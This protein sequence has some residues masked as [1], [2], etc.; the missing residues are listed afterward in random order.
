MGEPQSSLE[1]KR[2]IFDELYGSVG[3]TEVENELVDTPVFQ[4]LRRIQ[5]LG[6]VSLVY[7]GATHTRFSHSIGTVF[8]MDRLARSLKLST[9]SEILQLLRLVA[10]L[11]D[12]GHLP[13]SHMPDAFLK[14]EGHEA[15]GQRIIHE[16]PISDILTKHRVDPSEIVKVLNKS[17][18]ERYSILIDSDL[19]VDKMDYLMRDAHHTGVSY[20]IVDLD[21]LLR[22]IYFDSE[23][24]LCVR[25]KG[26][27][28][29]ENFVLARYY[30]Y[31]TVYHHSTV[32]SFELMLRQIFKALVD[33][34]KL[35][36][37]SEAVSKGASYFAGYN[38]D[39]VLRT[40][41]NYD[42]KNEF[43]KKLIEMYFRR[44]PLKLVDEETRLVKQKMPGR[45]HSLL[46]L[47]NKE[48]HL[49]GLAS[50]S[51]VPVEWILFDESKPI[52]LVSEEEA[53]IR[54]QTEEDSEDTVPIAK[55]ES[56]IAS[57]LRDV[58]RVCLRMYT[59][60]EYKDSLRN[61]FENNYSM[62][63]NHKIA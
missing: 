21:R 39:L 35:L 6:C 28:A 12:V 8:V 54:I 7:P 59:R 63:E 37:P 20:G 14:K 60:Q 62:I 27:Q 3:I 46:L 5:H 13:F 10:L 52:D 2:H 48:G 61:A 18:D 44:E 25:Y 47:K 33:D 32:A 56:S 17:S 42:G 38:D 55:D 30:M 16:T 34:D 40:M 19:D 26:K 57:V 50:A 22:T 58:E 43:L 29:L 41:L 15:L 9:N 23:K 11:H 31:S 45:Y 36:H 49:N 51:G 1:F 53:A 4:R 24:R